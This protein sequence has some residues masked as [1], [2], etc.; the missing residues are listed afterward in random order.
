MSCRGH[1]VEFQGVNNFFNINCS[2]FLY[3]IHLLYA[4]LACTYSKVCCFQVCC[5][6]PLHTRHVSFKSFMLLHIPNM[7]CQIG[8]S[9]RRLLQHDLSDWLT[10]CFKL[11]PYGLEIAGLPVKS[12]LK[13]WLC[14][15][16]K[17]LVQGPNVDTKKFLTNLRQ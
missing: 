3:L 8:Q 15:S 13:C 1:F 9:M 12:T 6:Y 7:T 16:H 17:I 11:G 5:W 4:D 10:H 14:Y 2:V